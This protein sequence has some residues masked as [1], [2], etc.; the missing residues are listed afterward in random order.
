VHPRR[1]DRL[2]LHLRRGRGNVDPKLTRWNV[3]RVL[4]LPVLR[5]SVLRLSVLRL[6]VLRLP[7]LRLPV[8]RLSRVRIDRLSPRK[9]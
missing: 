3:A 6:S 5:L 7:V 4:R 8:L 9:R 2:N 1:S